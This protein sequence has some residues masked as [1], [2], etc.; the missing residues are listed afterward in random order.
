MS[1]FMFI[2][3]PQTKLTFNLFEAL[4]CQPDKVF[5]L[6]DQLL[7]FGYFKVKFEMRPVQL[8]SCYISIFAALLSPF[9]KLLNQGVKK[10]FNIKVTTSI[11]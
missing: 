1:Q 2:V 3:C 8:Y 10:I 9:S 11:L 7:N 4:E 5:E 6:Q